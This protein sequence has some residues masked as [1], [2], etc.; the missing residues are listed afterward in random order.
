MERKIMPKSDGFAREAV[1]KDIKKNYEKGLKGKSKLKILDCGVGAGYIAKS[2]SD[3]L[4]KYRI[5]GCEAYSN[6]IT[7]IICMKILLMER[8]ENITSF[9]KLRKRILSIL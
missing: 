2:C 3:K 9:S 8:K 5:F 6:Y 7:E 1:V 4:K